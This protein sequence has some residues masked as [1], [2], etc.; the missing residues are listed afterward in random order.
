MQNHFLTA[1]AVLIT[2]TAVNSYA[3]TNVMCHTHSLEARH[4]NEARVFSTDHQVVITNTSNTPKTYNVLYQSIVDNSVVHHVD[5]E[6]IIDPGKS[7]ADNH[8]IDTPLV[9]KNKHTYNA[10]CRTVVYG[11]ESND[12]K[13]GG[14]IKIT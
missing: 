12:I 6:V 11:T 3:S 13:G 1:I 7:F 14:Y 10:Q 4:S 5:I 2:A 8:Q 9:F